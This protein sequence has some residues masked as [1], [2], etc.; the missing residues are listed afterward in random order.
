MYMIQQQRLSVTDALSYG[1]TLP[2]IAISASF[3]PDAKRTAIGTFNDAYNMYANGDLTMNQLFAL[4]YPIM[5]NALDG[6]QSPLSDQNITDMISQGISIDLT[7]GPLDPTYFFD[8]NDLLN[9][10]ETVNAYSVSQSQII[11]YTRLLYRDST[12]DMPY[13]S[14]YDTRHAVIWAGGLTIL[15]YEYNNPTIR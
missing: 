6:F 12:R 14:I 9:A 10:T 2:A 11:P 4:R 5:P 7:N 8:I 13:N 15:D 1:I 3:T